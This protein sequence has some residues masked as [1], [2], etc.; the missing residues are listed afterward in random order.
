MLRGSAVG[1][2][3]T[4]LTTGLVARAM[5][6]AVWRRAQLLRAVRTFEF[7]AFAGNA[8][9]E[10]NGHQKHGENFHRAAF[11]GGRSRKINPQET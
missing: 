11:V 2:G 4:V 6:T 10:G 5:S 1:F 7:M 8:E 9:Q 3:R